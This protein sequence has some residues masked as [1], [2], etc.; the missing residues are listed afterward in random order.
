MTK[1]L[2]VTDSIFFTGSLIMGSNLLKW[3]QIMA[4]LSKNTL[5]S[6]CFCKQVNNQ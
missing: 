3:A 5:G 2:V 6:I 4:Q 1:K